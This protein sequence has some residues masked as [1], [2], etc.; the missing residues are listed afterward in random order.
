M[1]WTLTL[2]QRI[3]A[4]LGMHFGIDQISVKDQGHICLEVID[5][6]TIQQCYYSNS[7]F[8]NNELHLLSCDVKDND[9]NVY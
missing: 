8:A 5:H 1:H 7:Y 4:W 9:T 2:Y 6:Q 3:I